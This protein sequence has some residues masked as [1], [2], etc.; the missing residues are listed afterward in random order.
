MF[1]SLFRAS[2]VGD[3]SPWGDWFFQPVPWRA[4][5]RQ[6][7]SAQT[8]M[9]LAAVFASVR[10]LAESMGILPFMLYRP[11]TAKRRRTLVTDH[12]LVRLMRR[13]N[14]FQN[15][16]AWRLMLQGHLA[17]RG[18]A[19]CQIVGD[20]AGGISELLPLH[21]DRIRP[22]LLS[23]GEYRWVY[24]GADGTTQRFTRDEVWHLSGLSDDGITG[25]AIV[26]Q[27]RNVIGAAQAMQDYGARFFE[28]DAKPTG[29][30]LE[31]PGKIPNDETKKTLRKSIGESI[32]GKNR[33]KTLVLDQGMK[34]HEVGLTN[35]DS[36]FLEARNYSRTEIAA[37]FRVPPHM[38]GDLSRATFSNI[39]QQ[40]IDF[41]RGTMAPWAECW[42]A[43]LEWLLGDDE[44]FEAHFDFRALLR[45]DS[46]SR[47]QYLQSLVLS[48]VLM[49]NE[50]RE[51]EGYDPIDGLDEP[52]VPVNERE[53]SQP[54]DG[55]QTSEPKR[56]P[57]QPDDGEDDEDP[58]RK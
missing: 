35:K 38:I 16:F 33:H 17:L 13:P 15:R 3:R 22:E 34:Y 10:V 7:V 50:G 37:M 55:V 2:D 6:A 19:Y 41:W 12:W 14:R 21:P 9:Q 52:L 25:L 26:D 56:P 57:E 29:G 40:S 58:G 31:Y 36:Q 32:G 47:S 54:Q 30:W 20:G 8:A 49:R 53:I 43:S 23:N 39:E 46:V 24:T 42:Q 4:G 27:Q 48:G 51:M 5:G 18:N 28:N 44:D 1:S 45:G 11:K